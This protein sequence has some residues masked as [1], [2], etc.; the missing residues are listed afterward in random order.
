MKIIKTGNL[1]MILLVFTAAKC[2]LPDVKEFAGITKDMSQ[3]IRKTATQT[4]DL[5]G[6]GYYARKTVDTEVDASIADDLDEI[7]GRNREEVAKDYPTILRND[8]KRIFNIL[9]EMTAYADALTAIR[10]SGKSGEESFGKVADALSSLASVAGFGTVSAP[11]KEVGKAIYGKIAE[12]RAAKKLE[13]VVTKSDSVITIIANEL[14]KALANMVEVNSVAKSENLLNISS[15]KDNER[16]RNYFLSLIEK[17]KVNIEKLTL[18]NRY[19]NGDRSALIFFVYR[20]PQSLDKLGL[21]DLQLEMRKITDN[22]QLSPREKLDAIASMAEQRFKNQIEQALN[23]QTI[24]NAIDISRRLKDIQSDLEFVRTEKG[25]Y[26]DQY[27]NILSAE[28]SIQTAANVNL[29]FIEKSRKSV[30]AWAGQHHA[31]KEFFSKKQSL[32]FSSLK[33][34]VEDIRELGT[35]IKDLNKKENGTNNTP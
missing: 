10:E 34:H 4:I 22:G 20:D 31:L 14:D 15:N 18:L 28:Q 12:I 32:S 27:N 24:I 3:S 33:Q 13:D 25:K 26:E 16:I 23:N 7:L 5:L 30:K 2:E 6:Q 17:E 21:K 8:W 35:I 11:I 29:E 1:L 19:D 9:E